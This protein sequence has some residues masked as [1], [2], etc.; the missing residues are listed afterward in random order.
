MKDLYESRFEDLFTQVLETRTRGHE[1]RLRLPRAR[2]NVR[3]HNFTVRV[4]Q[5]WNALSSEA[6]HSQSLR[7]FK[8][9]LDTESNGF[10]NLRWG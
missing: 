9:Y 8:K 4:V 5:H 2:T 3:K 7:V 6:V 10:R 1:F